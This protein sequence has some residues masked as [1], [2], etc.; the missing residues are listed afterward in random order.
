LFFFITCNVGVKNELT[1]HLLE[2]AAATF[3]IIKVERS[4]DLITAGAGAATGRPT[5][6]TSSI[7]AAAKRGGGTAVAAAAAATTGQEE[8]V[9]GMEQ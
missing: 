2:G 1:Q 9:E 3:T 8:E 6:P 5:P 7:A 4:E